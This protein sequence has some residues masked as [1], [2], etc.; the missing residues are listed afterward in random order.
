[1][2][3]LGIVVLVLI[4][5]LA[6]IGFYRNWFDFSTQRDAQDDSKVKVS[7]GVDTN[8]I[9]EDTA[10]AKDKA[11]ELGGTVQRN[12]KGLAGAETVKGE[13]VSV[14]EKD[15]RFTVATADKPELTIHMAPAAKLLLKDKEIQ[16]KDLR[17]GDRVTVAYEV[18]DGK[19]IAQS[20][21]VERVT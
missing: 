3:K 19:S 1:M 13:V 4:A 7:L 16:L 9:A 12:I 15:G 20:V 21:T 6:G 14:D 2:R 10:A 18:K 11:R 5:A 17:V 8:K